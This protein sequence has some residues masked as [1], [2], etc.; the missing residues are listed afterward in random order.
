MEDYPPYHQHEKTQP[1]EHQTNPRPQRPEKVVPGF[2]D[3]REYSAQRLAPA[4]LAWHEKRSTAKPEKGPLEDPDGGE[5]HIPRGTAPEAEGT[6]PKHTLNVGAN[7]PNHSR[8][9]V[10]DVAKP[11]MIIRYTDTDSAEK[12]PVSVIASNSSRHFP[13]VS[14]PARIDLRTLGPIW[15]RDVKDILTYEPLR[16]W[17]QYAD[18]YIAGGNSGL[19]FV[20]MP[21]DASQLGANS[22]DL[23]GY[24]VMKRR[25]AAEF[26]DMIRT[27]RFHDPVKL[28]RVKLAQTMMR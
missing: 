19:P 3:R 1:P 27:A 11:N 26:A 7:H 10:P 23:G 22:G 8:P 6:D 25:E 13:P 20:D 2:I 18:Y 5:P 28:R 9:V 12:Q 16:S 21:A 14:T 17:K 4:L 15:E 24:E